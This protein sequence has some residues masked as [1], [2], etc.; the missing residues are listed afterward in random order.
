MYSPTGEYL[1]NNINHEN[2][3][4]T[5]AFLSTRPMMPITMMIIMM[6]VV[7]MIVMMTALVFPIL[8]GH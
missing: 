1:N 6:M 8:I 7:M 4:A 5:A 3:H 2:K